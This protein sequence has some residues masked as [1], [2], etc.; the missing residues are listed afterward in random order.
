MGGTRPAA[1]IASPSAAA[2]LGLLA[3]VVAVGASMKSAEAAFSTK[4]AQDWPGTFFALI[5]RMVRSRLP[6]RA[7]NWGFRGREQALY[8]SRSLYSQVRKYAKLLCGVRISVQA[9]STATE[10]CYLLL[11]IAKNTIERQYYFYICLLLLS[12]YW[13]LLLTDAE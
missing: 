11:S 6:G 2:G 12:K 3:T 1:L 4:P 7:S 5:A 13:Y 10:Y 8:R 9:T